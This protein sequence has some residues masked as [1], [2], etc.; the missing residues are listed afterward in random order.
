MIKVGINGFGRI[1]KCLFLQLL[2]NEKYLITCLNAP[3]ILIND[4]Q[5]YLTYD[6]THK[7]SININVKIIDDN[8]FQINSHKIT[9]FNERDAKKILWDCH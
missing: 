6:S 3:N 7:H 2:E 4:I 5:D 9:L 8:T 1:G